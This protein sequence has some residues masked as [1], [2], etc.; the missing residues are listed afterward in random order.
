MTFSLLTPI[1]PDPNLVTAVTTR[2]GSLSDG[3]QKLNIPN[4]R[5][6]Q[7]NQIH[8]DKIVF[9]DDVPTILPEADGVF[10]QKKGLCLAIRTADC[11][12]ILMAHPSGLIGAIHAGRKGTEAGIFQK[13]LQACLEKGYF[14]G[15]QVWFGPA[16]S[17]DCYEVNPLT[18]ETFDLI[19]ENQRQLYSVFNKS[20]VQLLFSPYCTFKHNHLFFS[21]RK[22]GESAGRNYSL[23]M[24][25]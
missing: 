21:Y 8:S 24:V 20:H 5:V 22:E 19:A 13:A 15:W 9:V 7:L 1:F 16:I 3:V 10:T 11:L 17:A 2:L 18:H 23:I 6:V 25:R 14:D 12:P 4:H